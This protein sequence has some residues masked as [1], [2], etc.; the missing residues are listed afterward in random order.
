MILLTLGAV[1]ILLGIAGP[2]LAQTTP[3]LLKQLE[4]LQN[5][6][7]Q[8][9][10]QLQKT[11]SPTAVPGPVAVPSVVPGPTSSQP[12]LFPDIQ[13]NI[14]SFTRN[15]YLGVRGPE[16]TDLQEFLTEQGYYAGPV[17]GYFGLL[18]MQ[19][20]RKFQNAQGVTASGYFGAR[21]RQ[22]AN[23]IVRKL[24]GFVCPKEEGC[25]SDILPPQRL[26]ITTD[27]D[28]RGAVGERF[29]ATFRVSGGSGSY[30]LS[31]NGR[32]PGLAFSQTYC[33][34]GTVC[35]QVVSQDSVTLYGI[36][37]R[38]GVYSVEILAKDGGS[39]PKNFSDLSF[40]RA[41]FTVVIKGSGV[42]ANPPT[43]SGVKGPTGLKAGE[44]GIWTINAFNPGGGSLSYS[45]VWGD[46]EIAAFE[47]GAFAPQVTPFKQ[48]ADFSH[49]YRNLGVYTPTFKVV[50]DSGLE[51]GTSISVNVSGEITQF[52]ITIRNTSSLNGVL[53]QGFNVSFV[54]YGGIQPYNWSVLA[55]TLPSGL[56][57]V[58][59]PLP[60]SSVA[61]CYVDQTG[62][63]VCPEYP[64]NSIN[65]Q[66]VPTQAGS[67]KFDLKAQDQKGS[68]GTGTFM[69]VI[70]E[71]SAQKGTLQIYPV[72]TTFKVG[73]SSEL[74]AFYTPIYSCPAG[75][76]CA[77]PASAPV[78]ATWVSSNPAVATVS[79]KSIACSSASAASSAGGCFDL[80]SAV[81]RGVSGGTAEIQA[82][83][84]LASQGVLTAT[85]KVY[86]SQTAQAPTISSLSPFSG[87]AGA[88]VMVVGTGFTP[89][90]NDIHFAEGGIRNL[91]S[92]NNGTNLTFRV[93]NYISGCDFWTA[94][95]SCTQP[96]R[97]LSVGGYNVY[98]SNVNGKSNPAVFNVTSFTATPVVTVATTSSFAITSLS[99]ASGST[100]TNVTIIGVGFSTTGNTVKFGAGIM[101]SMASYDQ[102]TITI[103]VPYYLST[104]ECLAATGS[105]SVTSCPT[106]TAGP[107]NVS[108]TNASG[109]TSNSVPF[110][111]T[112]TTSTTSTTASG[113]CSTEQ[114][115]LLG[116]GCHSMGNAY[117]DGG[118][119]SY[120]LPGTSAVKSCSTSYISGCSGGSTTS[121]GS[122]GSTTYVGDANTC[123]G[124]AYPRWD[125]TSRR[126][127]QLNTEARC[128]YNYPS[129]LT[130]GA[131]YT[132]ANC[133]ASS[134][135]TG[136]TSGT[137]T[138]TTSSTSCSA[139]LITL[140][141]SGCHNVGNAWFDSGMT[142]YVLPGTNTVKNCSTN[143]L[144]GCTSGGGTTGGGTT[145][146]GTGTSSSCDSALTALLGTG[147]HYMYSDS[148]GRAIYCDGSMTVSAKMG[149]TA[150]TAGCSLSGGASYLLPKG[151]SL[152]SMLIYFQHQL[153]IITSQLNL[154]R[155]RR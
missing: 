139:E 116:S 112:G 19:A 36:P 26:V 4:D 99:P 73:E 82:S 65:L 68:S 2:T 97:E 133:P 50:N 148:S 21:T 59:P 155:S 106:V 34:P 110:T 11:Q 15:L 154:L 44:T 95:F 9:Q 48:T 8:L 1:L 91:S 56:S 153:E 29:A 40:G 5:Q 128:D 147:C 63:S 83:F 60:L 142:N 70:T 88:Q 28:L 80:E 76:Y 24:V 17:N 131:N 74:K 98:V 150:T 137:T 3:D 129:Y 81:V 53:G 136:T 124:F 90:G 143:Y 86:V 54:A 37:T 109:A 107:Y 85:T 12:P 61:P 62:R 122:T 47:R 119:T 149:D 115:N 46:E 79:Y 25:E 108:V 38:G 33:P 152:A 103:P 127:C 69:V 64:R 20:V 111:V 72:N 140:L 135:T 138:G 42:S 71:S 13:Q 22:I 31:Y 87:V 51:A 120:I 117:F 23:Q 57:L 96:V 43:I 92:S 130:N 27:S 14:P 49:V 118:M 58:E 93:P 30:G 123:P 66:G 75:A 7:R 10:A 145:Y 141:G 67:F 146:T 41:F 144:S 125:S 78:K 39:S 126:Y 18:T 114:I 151:S 84:D 121:T 35:I 45:V 32:V 55:G 16:V 100:G 94:S 113:I 101:P 105:S 77:Q 89:I 134:S 6:V 102:R 132:A 52:P 104:P